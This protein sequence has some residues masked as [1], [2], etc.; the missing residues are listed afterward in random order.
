MGWH[1]QLQADL[2]QVYT[3]FHLPGLAVAVLADG[4][5]YPFEFGYRNHQ[6]PFTLDTLCL[7]AS[8]SK[9]FTATLAGIL[10][11]QG[12]VEWEKPVR[13]YWPELQL[14]DEQA[15]QSMTLTDMLC[16]RTGLPSHENLLAEGVGRE[17]PDRG[18]EYRRQLLKRLAYFE[19][20]QAF[21]TQFQYQDLVFSGA[22]AILEE[23]TNRRY[24]DLIQEYCL[25]PL[26]MADS[27]FSRP[28]ALA[29]GR[30][31]QGYGW[32]DGQIQPIP[33][34]DT[35][36]IA[37]SAGLY[38]TANDL[39]RW[40]QFHLHGGSIGGNPLISEASLRW[41]HRPHMAIGAQVSLVGGGLA[42][43]G[44]G[45]V[46]SSIG[47]ELMLSHGGSFNGYRTTVA[48]IPARGFGVAVL[49]NLNVSNANT[50][51]ALVVMD[52]L[53]GQVQVE[54]RIAYGK[55]VAEGF[56]RQAA[57]AEQ[58]FWAGRDPNA[59][60]QHPLANYLGQF[61]H[62][63]YGT[64]TI[65]LGEG[66]LWQTYDQRTYPLDPYNG[67]T[68]STRF[69]STENRL[70]HLSLTFETDAKGQVVAVRIPI[71]EDISPP[72]FVRVA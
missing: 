32:V 16:H 10:V 37:P 60:P 5:V 63:G 21:R 68:F 11:D 31:A 9:S 4:E 66:R 7:V 36:Y 46:Q 27:T 28:A 53:L 26:G 61:H 35:R 52:R 40:L 6:E 51:G 30:L 47:S 20:A 34:C 15:T 33:H 1:P 24:E 64:F 38:S 65:S 58:A 3:A 55:Q 13:H 2:A 45:W 69:Q 71:V 49:T 19:P 12:Q 54:T 17:L 18:R 42:T 57:A 72:R 48:F 67:E 25:D 43:Y 59:L 44:L 56:A 14:M 22:G 50:I 29:T 41:I 8:V 39:M 70:L 62:P 23:V